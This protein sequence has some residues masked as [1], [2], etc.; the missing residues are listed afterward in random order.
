MVAAL[1]HYL[2]GYR[3]VRWMLDGGTVRGRYFHMAEV[4]AVVLV[5]VALWIAGLM[6]FL[7]LLV[8]T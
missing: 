1:V 8:A 7:Y 3:V 4:E 6:A 5:S 2:W